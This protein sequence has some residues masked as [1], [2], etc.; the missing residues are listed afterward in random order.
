LTDAEEVSLGSNPLLPIATMTGFDGDES[1]PTADNDGDGLEASSIPTATTTACRMASKSRWPG[2]SVRIRISTDRRRQRDGDGD[3]LPNG[4]EVLESTDTRNPDTDADGLFD[5]EEVIAGVD[6][7]TD[8]LRPDWTAMACRTD[9]RAGLVSI[10]RTR[11]TPVLIPTT[12]AWPT[13][14]SR[15]GEPT[16]ESDTTP[17][18]VSQIEPADGG[19]DSRSMA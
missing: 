1:S 5:G 14:R 8:P 13:S 9:T 11:P 18:A 6:G 17:P 16:D 4:E 19:P 2:S 15:S 10:P 3:G 12:T 7:L